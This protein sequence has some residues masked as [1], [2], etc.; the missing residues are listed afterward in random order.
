MRHDISS[1]LSD[2]EETKR[3]Q[4][5]GV[6]AKRRQGPATKDDTGATKR[7][8]TQGGFDTLGEAK[9]SGTSAEI[10]QLVP[11]HADRHDLH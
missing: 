3:S 2:D 8:R 4:R 10:A 9:E 6:G 7:D 5:C 11:T 1:E